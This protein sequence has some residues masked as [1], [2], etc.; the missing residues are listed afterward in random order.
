[1]NDKQ[2]QIVNFE[3][4]KRLKAAGFNREVLHYYT[5]ATFIDKKKYPDEIR[6]FSGGKPQNH[7]SENVITNFDEIISAP[8]VALALKW[9]RNVKEI[10]NG[11]RYDF[12]SEDGVR[13]DK[14]GYRY[15][16]TKWIGSGNGISNGG[17]HNTYEAAESSLL[18]E[19]LTLIETQ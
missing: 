11:I 18:D 13:I 15:E 8:T 17:F 5:L 4:A 2:L 10:H 6:L 7:N 14:W 9:F 1:M 12:E 3:Q 16:Y 19:L